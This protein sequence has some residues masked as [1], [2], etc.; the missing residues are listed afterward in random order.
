M[1]AERITTATE[2]VAGLLEKTDEAFCRMNM[3]EATR[4][5]ETL[6]ASVL[7]VA[8]TDLDDMADQPVSETIVARHQALLNRVSPEQ[9]VAYLVGRAPFLGLDFEVTRD[10]LI[11]R[12]DTELFL[13]IVLKEL[14]SRSLSTEAHVLE[15]CCGSGCIAATLARHCPG[16]QVMATDISPDALGVARRNIARH[17]LEKTVSFGVGDL[18]AP[19]EERA[20]ERQFDL[21]V[22]NPPYIPTEGIPAM[23]RQVAEHEPHLALDGGQDGLD[24][25]RRI[26]ADAPRFLAPGGRLFLEHEWDQGAAMREIACSYPVYCE[27][28][29]FRDA[30]GK[31][32]ALYAS[33]A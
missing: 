13:R 11:P 31:H 23:G 30:R 25:H 21:I 18:F 27:V 29:T 26:L 2:T 24:L 15:L 32:R 28:R 14:S 17:G 12:T 20:M 5:A 3:K 9:P 10:T 16:A 7:D 33:I 4:W 22:S 1:Y 8:T 19:V 6:V